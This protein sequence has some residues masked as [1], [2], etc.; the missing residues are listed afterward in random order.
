MVLAQ[1][2]PASAGVA[3]TVTVTAT[4]PGGGAYLPVPSASESVDMADP[5]TT[6]S[7]VKGHTLTRGGAPYVGNAAIG[8]IINYT[9]IVTNT[10]N[11]TLSG[12][13]ITDTHDISGGTSSLA[14]TE[15]LL[16]TTDNTP[17]GAS[18]GQTGDSGDGTAGDGVWDTLG[19][20]DV[21]TFTASHTVVASDLNSNGG[22]AGATDGDIDNSAA[23]SGTYDPGTGVLTATATS[24]DAVPLEITPLLTITKVA[25][26]DTDVVAG[27]IITYTYT[28]TNGGNVDMSA[29]TL[30]DTHKGVANALT[31]AFQ[32]FA[33][34]G[35]GSVASGNTITV[36]KPGDS[37]VFEATYTVTQQDI[38]TLQ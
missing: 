11:V 2:A 16:V 5:V 25:D 33:P 32:N 24:T 8:D 12:V 9:Y 20:G 7:I 38:D 3:N 15:P 19:A 13:D 10:G 36:L 35:L 26:D 34:D 23:V 30:E 21:I 29:I 37:A 31:P 22:G 17:G 18:A 4:Q 27:Q 1:A 6:I 14:V 28:V